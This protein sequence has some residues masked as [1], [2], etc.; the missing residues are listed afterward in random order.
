[1]CAC[2]C[3]R[4]LVCVFRFVLRFVGTC[5]WFRVF[6][7]QGLG[8][9]VCSSICGRLRVAGFIVQGLGCRVYG[10]FFGL[11]AL[12]WFRVKGLGLR[13]EGV[14]LGLFCACVRL[15][16]CGSVCVCAGGLRVEGFGFRV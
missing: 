16:S 14:P 11:W 4:G 9:R 15:C 3:A 8:F 1:M 2:V 10:L 13:V 5:A 7:V 6:V 12:A